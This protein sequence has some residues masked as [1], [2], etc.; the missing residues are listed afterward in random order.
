MWLKIFGAVVVLVGILF[1]Y[2]ARNIIQKHFKN[3][4]DE[5]VAVFG[6]KA[7]GTIIAIVGGMFLV[8]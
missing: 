5:N 8:L 1:V 4:G 3:L 7:F 2:E 6:A